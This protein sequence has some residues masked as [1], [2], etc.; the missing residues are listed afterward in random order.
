MRN[1]FGVWT[2]RRSTVVSVQ[3]VVRT[4]AERALVTRAATDVTVSVTALHSAA[5]TMMLLARSK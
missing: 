4:S 3:Q 2:N 1:V 5:M